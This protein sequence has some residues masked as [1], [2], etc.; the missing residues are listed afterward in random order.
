M[1]ANNTRA[2]A[3]A[4]KSDETAKSHL[5]IVAIVMIDPA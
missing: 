3:K 4:T 2:V 5:L 1:G